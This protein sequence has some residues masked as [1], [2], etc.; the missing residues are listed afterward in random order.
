MVLDL[1]QTWL[2]LRENL[3]S[4]S[5][6]LPLMFPIS[7]GYTAVGAKDGNIFG[8]WL[9]C[10]SRVNQDFAEGMLCDTVGMVRRSISHLV[11]AHVLT[12]CIKC[13]TIVSFSD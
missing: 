6:L 10:L 3:G 7:S 1:I 11:S 5:R 2:V 13:L 12:M 4:G 8:F 9:P